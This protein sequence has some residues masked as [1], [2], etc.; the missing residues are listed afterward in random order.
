MEVTPTAAAPI[1]PMA[2]TPV[3]IDFIVFTVGFPL[4][5]GQNVL[6]SELQFCTL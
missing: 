3:A 4:Q 1:A 6:C 2:A 5:F